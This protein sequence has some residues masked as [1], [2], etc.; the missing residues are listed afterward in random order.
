MKN[1][2]KIFTATKNAV[3]LKLEPPDMDAV[4]ESCVYVIVVVVV[5]L[6][7][8]V[9]VVVVLVVVVVVIVVVVVVVVVVVAVVVVV[10]PSGPAALQFAAEI[11]TRIP[12]PSKII[13]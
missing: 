8:V 3:L 9:V 2:N 1:I 5:V 4:D 6:D 7:V 13:V 11:P 12:L 10:V